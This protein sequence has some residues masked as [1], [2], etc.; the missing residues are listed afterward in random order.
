M[1]RTC[2]VDVPAVVCGEEGG[3]AAGHDG[4]DEDHEA[5]HVHHQPVHVPLQLGHLRPGKEA[6]RPGVMQASCPSVHRHD[7]LII[8]KRHT[9]AYKSMIPRYYASV[10]PWRT[11]A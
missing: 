9:P 6:P 7:T 8:H 3:V 11:K 10:T 5:E 4:G 1:V 2:G